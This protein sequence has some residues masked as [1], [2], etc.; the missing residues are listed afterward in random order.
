MS[1]R[2]H[3]IKYMADPRRREPRN[4]GLA[5]ETPDGWLLKFL[6]EEKPGLINGQKIRSTHLQKDVYTSWVEYYRRKATLN[7]WTDVE[8]LNVNRPGNFFTE[9]AGEIFETD[10]S[11]NQLLKRLYA[12]LVEEPKKLSPSEIFHSK[13][14]DVFELAQI[15]PEEHVRVPAKWSDSGENVSVEFD[16]GYQNGQFHVMDAVSISRMSSVLDFK[17]RLDAVE[18]AGNVR[19]FVALCSYSQVED[20]ERLEE[21]LRP[22]ERGART[23]DVDETRDAAQTL[24]SIMGH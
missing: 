19:S 22:L 23:I 17:A 14:R 9:L 4:V 15:E 12:E 5:L 8:H 3:L 16:F 10:E 6:G 11:A 21:I 24:V 2:W 7:R 13:I 18:R 1:T 20:A